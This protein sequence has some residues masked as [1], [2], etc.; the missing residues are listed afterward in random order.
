M[1]DRFWSALTRFVACVVAIL[2]TFT[3]VMYGRNWVAA[4]TRVAQPAG[5]TAKAAPAENGKAAKTPLVRSMLEALQQTDA[6]EATDEERRFMR[7]QL[8]QADEQLSTSLGGNSRSAIMRANNR[9]SAFTIP[10]GHG[11]IRGPIQR[12]RP[13]P[14]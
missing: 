8:L 11:S 7:D 13:A 14:K 1:W 3:F 9:L 12:I 10:K 5:A 6:G 2:A 4:E